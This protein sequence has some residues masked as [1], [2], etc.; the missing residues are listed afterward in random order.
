MGQGLGQ[1]TG[2][3]VAQAGDPCHAHAFLSGHDGLGY[4][5]HAHGIGTQEAEGADFGWGLVAGAR[6]AQV[7]AFSHRLAELLGTGQE[8]APQLGIVDGRHVRE[9]G[10]GTH[11]GTDEGIRAE[12]VDVV[13]E[14][15]EF[16]HAEGGIKGPSC[17]GQHHGLHAQSAIEAHGRDHEGHGVPLVEVKA[18]RLKDDLAAFELA[19]DQLAAVALDGG[20]G[21]AG[22]VCEG[23]A[24]AIAGFI[25]VR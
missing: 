17:I 20:G 19:K 16:T 6:E 7:D 4:G 23:N 9:A 11:V 24:D 3:H 2:A 14:G 10:A 12:E 22:Q 25:A 13:R 1:D 18:A 5:A 21:E 15:H 8:V